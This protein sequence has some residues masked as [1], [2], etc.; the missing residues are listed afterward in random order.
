MHWLGSE[1]VKIQLVWVLHAP[2][3]FSYPPDPLPQL[4]VCLTA[5]LSKLPNTFL[6]HRVHAVGIIGLLLL[7]VW[8]P[9]LKSRVANF[10]FLVRASVP[11]IFCTSNR[12]SDKIKQVGMKDEGVKFQGIKFLQ[13]SQKQSKKTQTPQEY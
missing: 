3:P 2:L 7:S 13:R 10:F 12:R 1:L 5:S 11:L 8:N 4:V 6:D 9:Q